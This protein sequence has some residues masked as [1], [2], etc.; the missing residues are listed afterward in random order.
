MGD[1][2]VQ[3]VILDLDDTLFDHQESARRGVA[4]LIDELGATST[5]ER[6]ES[7]E[8]KAKRLME[9][10][11]AGEIDRDGYR[12][13]R[14]RVLF[15]DLGR[16]TEAS[17][18]DEQECDRIYDRFVGVYEE[19]WVAFPDATPTLRAIQDRRIPV[20]ILTN[21]PEERQQRKVR[22]LGLDHLVTGVWT[23][24]R[25]GASKPA[26]QCY[27]T[28]CE[29]LVAE[30]GYVLHVGDNRELD[31]HGAMAAG[32]LALHLDRRQDSLEAP[33]R[34]E[35]LDELLGRV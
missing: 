33:H 32:L 5:P 22:A 35:G 13:Q 17:L 19:E 9:R 16:A 25:I 29:A 15:Q 6:V 12:R 8:N 26:A 27:L 18:L 2:R 4:R 10:R 3:A 31:L 24:E 14:V 21:G 23:S 34:I 7:W 1:A 20:A 11:R 28:V 30:P